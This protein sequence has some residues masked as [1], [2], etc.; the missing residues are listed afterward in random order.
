MK[1]PL[2]ITR[3]EESFIVRDAH[4]V[5]IFTVYFDEGD[6]V[7]RGVR[8]R[9]DK[10]EAEAIAKQIARLLTDAEKAGQPPKEPAG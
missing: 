8:K 7:R 6:P 2:K 9:L 5:S 3:Y 1:L 10:V 4:E